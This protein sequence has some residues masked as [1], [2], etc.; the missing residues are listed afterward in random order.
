MSGS[1][2]SV[3][4]LEKILEYEIECPMCRTQMKVEEYLY[5]MP[6]VG[7]V[8]IASG[9]C[10]ECGYRFNDVRLAEPRGPRRII[11]RVEQPGDEN[12]LVI[13][14][15]TASIRIPELGIE[16]TP[17]PASTGYI[18]TVEG[19]LMDVLEKVEF[20]C[21]T[22]EASKEKCEEVKKAIREAMDARKKFTLIIEDPEGVSAILSDKAVIEAYTQEEAAGDE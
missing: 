12:A 19:I 16:I 3:N 20:L 11:Y 8:L 10:R 5:N 22:G 1:N 17:G 7:K 2:T 4:E 18:T 13:R 6:M 21:S 15:S 9:R 14:A